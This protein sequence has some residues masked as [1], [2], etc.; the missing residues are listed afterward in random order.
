MHI[1][2]RVLLL[3]V[4][5]VVVMSACARQNLRVWWPLEA[6]CK[7]A[8]KWAWP[9]QTAS[10]RQAM[11]LHSSLGCSSQLRFE[12]VAYVLLYSCKRDCDKAAM[13]R[14]RWGERRR[15]KTHWLTF[16]AS[17]LAARLPV[18]CQRRRLFK[19][20]TCKFIC[21]IKRYELA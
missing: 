1:L 16:E 8:C 13:D 3:L 2:V 7:F 17:E 10:W 6:S 18:V 14:A 19:S 9:G 11:R 5:V 4:A 21:C 20:A 15:D 12:L